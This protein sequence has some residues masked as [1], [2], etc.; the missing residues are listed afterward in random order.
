MLGIPCDPASTNRPGARFGPRALR[1][2]SAFFGEA[3]DPLGQVR[4]LAGATLAA[5]ILYLVA[6]ARAKRSGSP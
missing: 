3:Y 2:Q 6:L 4:A 5:D 1:E